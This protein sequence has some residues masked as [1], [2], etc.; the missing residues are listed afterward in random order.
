MR[1]SYTE[2][3]KKNIALLFILMIVAV[4][5]SGFKISSD[6]LGTGGTITGCRNTSISRSMIVCTPQTAGEDTGTEHQ[7]NLEKSDAASDILS[8]IVR[9]LLQF[10][11]GILLS[12]ATIS[13]RI[14]LT[15]ICIVSCAHLFLLTHIRFIHLKD[16]SK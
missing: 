14:F 10:Q 16:G 3:I 13:Y 12:N 1:L 11:E 15:S 9:K 5:C 8:R 7:N 4:F 6:A 2:V